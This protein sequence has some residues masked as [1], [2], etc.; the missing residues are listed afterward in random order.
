M[1][2][3]ITGGK[4]ALCRVGI[5]DREVPLE[6]DVNRGMIRLGPVGVKNR[7]YGPSSPEM[8]QVPHFK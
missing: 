1:W 4:W 7:R 3:R 5:A 6:V 2:G 8:Y